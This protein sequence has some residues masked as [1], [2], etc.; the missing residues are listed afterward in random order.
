MEA[1]GIS[2]GRKNWWGE[3]RRVADFVFAGGGADL[4][5]GYGHSFA[6]ADGL[7]VSDIV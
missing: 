1:S 4:Y 7:A 5:F 2:G 3:K 6:G